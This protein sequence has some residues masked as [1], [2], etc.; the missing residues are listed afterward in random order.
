MMDFLISSQGLCN[1]LAFQAS[2]SA[3]SKNTQ[4]KN[5]LKDNIEALDNK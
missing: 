3:L 5:I 4:W 1:E 2:I